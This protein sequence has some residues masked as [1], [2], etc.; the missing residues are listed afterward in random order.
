M[1]ATFLIVSWAVAIRWDCRDLV[2]TAEDI[3]GFRNELIALVEWRG[4]NNMHDCAKETRHQAIDYS[5]M[6]MY[7]YIAN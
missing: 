7:R 6:R 4:I 2:D 5:F 3:R 1:R